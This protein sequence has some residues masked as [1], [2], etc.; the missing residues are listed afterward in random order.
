MKDPTAIPS[1]QRLI[2]GK[3]GPELDQA[4]REFAARI[5]EQ[6]AF[7]RLSA[8]LQRPAKR[9]LLEPALAAGGAVVLGVGLLVGAEHRLFTTPASE[10]TAEPVPGRHALDAAP[11]SSVEGPAPQAVAGRDAKEAISQR[12][13]PEGRAI[14]P[15]GPARPLE[16]ENAPVKPLQP[17]TQPSAGVVPVPAQPEGPD[18]LSLARGGNTRAAETCFLSRARGSG[19]GAEMAL[20]EVARLRRDVLADPGGALQVLAE[21]RQRFPAGALRREA[22]MSQL[23][24][25]MQLGRSQD[26][27][28]QSQELLSSSV[29]GERAA[30]LRVLRGHI[31]RKSLKDPRGAEREYALAE[32][33][34]GGNGVEASYFRGTSLQAMGDKDSAA[35]AY[36]RYLER[37]GRTY[38][39]DARQRLESLAP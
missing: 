35:A 21:Y 10:I 31:L 38:A 22:D 17:P 27:L 37:G 26:A 34:Q 14:A 19:L 15:R 39:A 3:L 13:A 32:A 36:Q 4:N 11:R 16:L 1:P 25:L 33:A 8:R 23:E 9:R 29:T 5:D 20:Y 28:R 7:R 24:L 12:K 30:E 2:H 18:C 6:A